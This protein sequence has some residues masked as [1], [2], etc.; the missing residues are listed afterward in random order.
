MTTPPTLETSLFVLEAMLKDPTDVKAAYEMEIQHRERC[1][2][3]IRSSSESNSHRHP[4]SYG[5]T[6]DAIKG[7][8]DK[9]PGELQR[10]SDV[11]GTSGVNV[12]PAK[13]SDEMTPQKLKGT[14][15]ETAVPLDVF[16]A[17]KRLGF[18]CMLAVVRFPTMIY[19]T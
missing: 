12:Y 19:Q 1:I 10:N 15:V 6:M 14:L 11:P 9:E 4:V 18:L 5:I 2:E 17:L 7:F 16:I 8:L 13:G 3:M